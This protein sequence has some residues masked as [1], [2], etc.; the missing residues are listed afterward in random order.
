[1]KRY[2][3]NPALFRAHFSGQGLPAFK[4]TRIQRGHGSWVSKLKRYAV[5]LLAAGVQAAAP[6]VSKL[7]RNVVTHAA[8][9]MFGNNPAMQ[10]V[11]G[12]VAGQVAD[13]VV[14][15]V[16]NAAFKKKRKRVGGFSSQTKRRATT[17]RNIFA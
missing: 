2:V 14:G 13:N 3:H 4:G 17:G 12:H 7:A 5:P 1:M 9:R 16:T 10:Q 15:K 6:H 11:V 8:Q